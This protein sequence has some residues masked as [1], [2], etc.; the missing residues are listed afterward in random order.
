MPTG[1]RRVTVVVPTHNRAG[2]LPGLLEALEAQDLPRDAFDVIVVDDG[3]TDETPA[4][5]ARLA[6][7]S[8]L[9]VQSIRI[10][11]AAGPAVARNRG[12]RATAAPVVAFID[13]DCLPTPA[14]LESGLAQLDADAGIGVVQGRTLPD[15]AGD[16]RTWSATRQVLSPSPFFEGCNL[17]VR[18]EALETA[19]GFDEGL[20]MGS[21]DTA[22]GWAVV[23]AGWRRGFAPSAVV[24][25]AVTDPG[26]AWHIRQGLLRA[27]L[28]AVAKR[29]PSFRNE[30][31]RPWAVSARGAAFAAATAGLAI[32]AAWAPA[33]LLTVPYAWIN[34]PFRP[35]NVWAKRSVAL[36]VQDVAN[37]VGTLRGSLRYGV[38]LV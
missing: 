34:R 35:T 16:L 11:R 8:G 38:L 25:H 3:S 6:G 21:E 4:V 33:A 19:G 22:L 7:A 31:W 36:G 13:D 12:W 26:P 23:D 24:H 20:G 1:D 30:L 9:R 2:G 32:G 17:F 29:H 27:N 18:R 37:L 14:W 28:A 10:E 5:L 15:P